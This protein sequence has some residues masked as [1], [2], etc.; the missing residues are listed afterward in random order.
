MRR[1]SERKKRQLVLAYYG[2][3]LCFLPTCA[4]SV[5]VCFCLVRSEVGGSWLL[6]VA[7]RDVLFCCLLLFDGDGAKKREKKEEKE[8]EERKEGEKKKGRKGEVG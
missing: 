1:R 2:S 4:L 3:L 8:R 7:V 5:Y 6:L